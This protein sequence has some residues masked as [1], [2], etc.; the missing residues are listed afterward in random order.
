M[1]VDRSSVYRGTSSFIKTEID[2]KCDIGVDLSE[3]SWLADKGIR[4]K[5]SMPV[6]RYTY[7]HN[8]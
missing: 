5:K 7:I 8:G 1:R 4:Y 2:L 6:I 3:G